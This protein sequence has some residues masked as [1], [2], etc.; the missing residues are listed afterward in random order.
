MATGSASK[1]LFL[2]I[3]RLVRA[4]MLS[5]KVISL[6]SLRDLHREQPAK[7]L[8]VEDDEILR[9]SLRRILESESYHVV[10]AQDATELSTVVENFLFDLIIM[11]VGLPWINGFELAEL[12]KQHDQIKHIPLVFISGHSE[13][14]MIKK[15][16]RVG[17]DD[18]LTKP[19]DLEKVKKTVRTLLY[20]NASG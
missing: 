3:E 15:G 19:F 2:K 1:K 6:Q 14:E 10:T 13:V 17:A 18:Y 12:M 7:I 16:F 8:V 11:D 5:E 9:K 4:R 20:L